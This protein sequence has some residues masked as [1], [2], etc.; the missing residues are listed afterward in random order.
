MKKLLFSVWFLLFQVLQCSAQSP[1]SLKLLL[2]KSKPDTNRVNLLLKLG[3]LNILPGRYK[4]SMMDSALVYAQQANKLAQ[5]LRY[6]PGYGN[7][8]LL[9]ATVYAEK[10]ARTQGKPFAQKAIAIFKVYG[11]K[12]K[13]ADSYLA[14]TENLEWEGSDLI[15]MIRLSKLALAIYRQEQDKEKEGTA[16]KRWGKVLM[17]KG[18]RE[19]G[20]EK[21]KQSLVVYQSVNYLQVQELYSLIGLN[22]LIGGKNE[23]ALKYGLLAVKT[24]EDLK[25]S[26]QSAAVIYDYIGVTY[27]K[28]VQLESADEYF[29][30]GL[31]IAVKG[32]DT[33][34]IYT[35]V[36]N[37]CHILLKQSKEREAIT[38]LKNLTQN[39]PRQN[40]M[41][42]IELNTGFLKAYM[43]LKEYKNAEVYC[44]KLIAVEAKCEPNNPYLI[45]MYPSVCQYFS[46]TKQFD[47]A[48]FYLA[49]YKTLC[50]KN[51]FSHEM[52]YVQIMW[53]KVD[54]LQGNYLSAIKHYQLHKTIKDS[55]YNESKANK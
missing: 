42:V 48:L 23:E 21:L 32:S 24:V 8:C 11:P 29:K 46:E 4:Q 12:M 20:L 49:K 17:F 15:E 28:L 40:T 3:E 38:Y 9:L 1:E 45:I 36:S 26:S 31:A 22:Y 51:E 35:L 18:E 19:K 37:I 6:Y 25:D 13:L 2:L 43:R 14:L 7:S 41:T 16:L 50:G 55:L 30:K 27:E 34:L 10:Q 33:T 52:S 39:Y 53:F 47:K 5:S 54:S 44:K